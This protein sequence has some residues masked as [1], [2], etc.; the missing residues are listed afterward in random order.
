M[1]ARGARTAAVS[2]CGA[3]VCSA[4]PLNKIRNPPEQNVERSGCSDAARY[5]A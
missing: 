2:G 5:S 1:A 3:S 4:Q